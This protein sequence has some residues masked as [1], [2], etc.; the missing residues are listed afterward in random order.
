MPTTKTNTA[1]ILIIP[2][3]IIKAAIMALIMNKEQSIKF[4]EA[5]LN[6]PPL[7]IS[8]TMPLFSGLR[9]ARNTPAR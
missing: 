4:Y 5:Q 1:K 9:S 7:I 6:Y 8:D 2:K 3:P